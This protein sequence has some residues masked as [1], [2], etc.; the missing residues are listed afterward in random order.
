MQ[1]LSDAIW[2]LVPR[3]SKDSRDRQGTHPMLSD[4]IRRAIFPNGGGPL[5]LMVSD[6]IWRYVLDG[7]RWWYLT[8]SDGMFGFHSPHARFVQRFLEHSSTDN[9]WRAPKITDEPLETIFES[10]Y[11]FI[12][13]IFIKTLGCL[14]NMKNNLIPIISS[15]NYG[16]KK[17]CTSCRWVVH[18]YT[19]N[20]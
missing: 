4:A 18:D 10:S 6:A 19:S 3:E 12:E 17:S 5:Y 1:I 2:R 16:W 14:H 20:V 7:P 15:Q 9:L 8:L 11:H 13:L